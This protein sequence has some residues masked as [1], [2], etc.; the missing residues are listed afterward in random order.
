MRKQEHIRCGCISCKR[1]A[2]TPA[3]QLIHR[4]TNRRIRHRTKQLLRSLATTDD[5]DCFV[6]VVV[7]TPYTD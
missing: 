5:Y 3:G 7:S 1:G 6:P 2:G 4:A